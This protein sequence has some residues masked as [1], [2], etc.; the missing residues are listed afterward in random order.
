MENYEVIDCSSESRDYPVKNI[1]TPKGRWETDG[2]SKNALV[3]IQF[4]EEIQI[5]LVKLE[6]IGSAFVEIL[7]RNEKDKEF[8]VLLPIKMV[9]S[10]AD[11]KTM[12][13]KFQEFSFNVTNFSKPSLV[14]K[15]KIMRISITQPWADISIG[16]SRLIVFSYENMPDQSQFQQKEEIKR[17]I[18]LSSSSSEESATQEM[19]IVKYAKQARVENSKLTFKQIKE[20]SCHGDAELMDLNQ[21]IREQDTSLLLNIAKNNP[22]YGLREKLCK[23]VP[24]RAED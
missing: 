10:F 22:S 21:A 3:D 9:R 6:N 1:Q 5:G 8:Q 16:L 4:E 18:K 7:V 11:C 23:F 24:K 20:M 19:A 15:W 12:K 13:N 2:E 14:K 17:N